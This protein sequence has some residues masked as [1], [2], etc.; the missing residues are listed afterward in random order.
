MTAAIILK[1]VKRQ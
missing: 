1:S